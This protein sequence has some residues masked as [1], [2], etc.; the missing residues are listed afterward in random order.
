MPR[1]KQPK[2]C[3]DC[4]SK[5][6]KV[7]VNTYYDEFTGIKKH[8]YGL[9]CEKIVTNDGKLR[10]FCFGHTYISPRELDVWNQK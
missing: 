9:G 10:L 3:A 2:F 1:R 7:I 8:K 5:L 6:I 4:G